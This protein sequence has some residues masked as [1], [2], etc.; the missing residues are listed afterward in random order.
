MSRPKEGR[1]DLLRE[2]LFLDVLTD[3]RTRSIFIYAII[4][5]GGVGPCFITGWRV[6]VGWIHFTLWSLP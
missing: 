1:R 2:A 4:V 3:R 5:M 6:G